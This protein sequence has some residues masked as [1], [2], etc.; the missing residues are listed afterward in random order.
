MTIANVRIQLHKKVVLLLGSKE[1][2][3]ISWYHPVIPYKTLYYQNCIYAQHQ[4][5]MLLLVLFCKLR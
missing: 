2:V 5:V 1:A 4:V 3:Y